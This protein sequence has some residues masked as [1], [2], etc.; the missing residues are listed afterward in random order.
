MLIKSLKTNKPSSLLVVLLFGGVLLLTNWIVSSEPNNPESYILFPSLFSFFS[1]YS[2]IASITIF[3]LA[4]FMAFR[5]NFIIADNGVLKNSGYLLAFI[6]VLITSIFSISSIWA[7]NVIFLFV[8]QTLIAMYYKRNIYGS[9]FD[10]GFLLGLSLLIYLPSILF[11]LL[12]YAGIFV[13]SSPTW[14]VIVIPIL[15]L[16]TPLIFL[17]S[18][19]YYF[20]LTDQLFSHYFSSFVVQSALVNWT[21]GTI[22]FVITFGGMSLLSLVEITKWYSVKNL[23]SRKIYSL[24]L[25]YCIGVFITLFFSAQ[26]YNHLLL[27]ALPLSLS[28]A[29]Y[30]HHLKKKKWYES[31]F[32]ILILAVLYY[33]I[34]LSI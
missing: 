10:A 1:S 14:R 5:W 15:G 32:L 2:W 12:I 30:F 7:I 26:P 20:D 11:I 25:C 29:N 22:V 31:A 6:F 21:L 13:Y 24:L 17:F 33:K 3:I 9:L 34:S 19:A 8:L 27:L 18:Y 4:I 16:I 28:L 23:Q